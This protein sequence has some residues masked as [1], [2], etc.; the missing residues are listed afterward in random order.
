[1]N[2]SFDID[3]AVRFGVPEAILIENF[4]FW[5]AKN[6]ANGRHFHKGRYWTY[7]STK[8]LAELFPYWS[9]KQIER[10]VKRLEDAGILLSDNF[11]PSPYDR[12]K[13]FSL[14]DEIHFPES[15]NEIPGIGK[16]TKQTDINT[17]VNTDGGE[18]GADA[19][20]T[21]G[22]QGDETT[23]DPKPAPAP[24]AP[25]PPPEKQDASASNAIQ[26]PDDVT[27]QTWDDWLALRKQKRAPVTNTVV[28]MARREAG[29]AD[30]PLEDFLQV[31]C[32]RGSQ[33][34]QASWLQN[35]QAPVRGGQP[36]D[37]SAP[38]ETYAQRAARQR[39]E[40]ISPMVAR[41][42]P[43]QRSAFEAAQAFMNGAD[44]IDVTEKQ[45]QIGGNHGG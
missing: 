40:E 21:D 42:A 45:K 12:T 7:N 44:I 6:K 25:P 30:M 1:M 38:V 16:S 4:K 31:W 32:V 18:A 3:L 28:T 39:V 27:Q 19:R 29:K 15:G 22:A 9:Q 34:L 8:A 5:I 26:C 10:L 23:A 2:H 41:K 43:G 36:I 17:D 37:Q 33:G 24:P 13:W 14:S 20:P 11:N 35:G